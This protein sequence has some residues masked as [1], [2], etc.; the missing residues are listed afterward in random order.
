MLVQI[1]KLLR[2]SLIVVCSML[3][4]VC[5]CVCVCVY[6]YVCVCVCGV[7]SQWNEFE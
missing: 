7:S 6:V 3:M 4:C 1:W 2:W 5:V